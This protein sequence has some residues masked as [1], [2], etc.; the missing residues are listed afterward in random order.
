MAKKKNNV[1]KLYQG[2]ERAGALYDAIL[3][4]IEERGQEMPFVTV[5]GIL[6][7]VKMNLNQMQNEV[8]EERGF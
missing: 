4:V 6:E 2:D 7:M 5:V 1:V 8:M 3:S